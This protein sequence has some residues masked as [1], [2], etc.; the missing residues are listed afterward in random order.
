[1]RVL[2]ESAVIRY[3]LPTSAFHPPYQAAWPVLGLTPQ[4]LHCILQVEAPISNPSISKRWI[5]W[6]LANIRKWNTLNKGCMESLSSQTSFHPRPDFVLHLRLQQLAYM[7]QTNIH[8]AGFNK[9]IFCTEGTSFMHVLDM[10]FQLCDSMYAKM[11]NVKLQHW[12]VHERRLR[13]V[14]M[15]V[16]AQYWT[17]G[18]VGYGMLQQH[19]VQCKAPMRPVLSTIDPGLVDHR[20]SVSHPLL[21]SNLQQ[22]HGETLRS[23]CRSFSSRDICPYKGQEGGKIWQE[24]HPTQ[25][26]FTVFC[27]RLEGMFQAKKQR[28]LH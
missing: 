26:S 7:M 2:L 20:L 28:F 13:F 14:Q 25:K 8:G 23:P 4:L 17:A 12:E 3:D 10:T 1:M 19:N 11:L 15:D 21:S 9:T 5:K 24:R 6:E 27:Y 22:S 18:R 16:C